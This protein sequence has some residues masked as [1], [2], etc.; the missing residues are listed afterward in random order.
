MGKLIEDLLYLSHIGRHEIKK[1]NIDMKQLV[2]LIFN[3]LIEATPN[4]E[5]I[6][7]SKVLPN[8][9]V[10]QSLMRQVW[11][12]LISNAIK[13]TQT[14]QKTLIEIARKIRTN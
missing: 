9:K 10:D 1:E 3:E 5:I 4:R 8:A 7:N 11:V 2:N 14:K 6:L 12:N 13:F